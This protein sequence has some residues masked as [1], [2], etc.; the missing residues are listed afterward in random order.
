MKRYRHLAYVTAICLGTAL[1]LVL[2]D[3]LPFHLF[4]IFHR[5]TGIPCPG[6]GLTRAGGHLL[7]AEWREALWC[8]PMVY[9]L[10]LILT[11]LF[12]SAI[13]D[14]LFDTK[15][16]ERLSHVKISWPVIVVLIILVAANWAWNIFKGL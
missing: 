14:A 16:F 6:C 3:R 10:A 11:I 2:H 9:P 12:L 8:N 13:V 7:H 4:C 1:Y 5:F 15:W